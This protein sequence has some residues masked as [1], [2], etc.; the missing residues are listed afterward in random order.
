MP[1]LRQLLECTDCLLCNLVVRLCLLCKLE[2]FSEGLVMNVFQFVLLGSLGATSV[3]LLKLYENRG[4]LP[5]KKY[6]ALARSQLFW[7]VT[8]G[9][10]LSSGFIAWAVHADREGVRIW[11]IVITGI[12]ARSVVRGAVASKVA[13]S[14]TNLG[15]HESPVSVRDIFL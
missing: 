1:P 13:N 3:E 2:P 9:M 7:L 12:A 14:R 4:K 11:D 15:V 5:Q 8:M 6:Q 10:L